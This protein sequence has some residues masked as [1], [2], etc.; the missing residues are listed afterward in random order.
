MAA[1]TPGGPGG[2]KVI[3]KRHPAQRCYRLAMVHPAGRIGRRTFIGLL[4]ALT[5]G[6]QA[7]LAQQKGK[8]K[9]GFLTQENPDTSFALTNLAGALRDLGYGDL[10]IEVR[11]GD[12]PADLLAKAAEL[13]LLRVDVVFAFQTPAA[14]AAKQAISDIPIVFLAADPV[15]SGLVDNI[16]HPG[17]NLTGVSAAVS[18]LGPKNLELIKELFP[19]FKRIVVLGNE[20]D[21]YHMVFRADVEAAGRLLDLDLNVLMLRSAPRVDAT[22]TDVLETWSPDALL[23]QPSIANAAIADLAQLYRLP[24]VSPNPSFVNVGGLIS[25]SA[26][27]SAVPRRLAAMIAE[28]LRGNKPA[29]IPV[30]LP[31]K[32]WLA[33]NLKTAKQLGLDIAQAVLARADQFIE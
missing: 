13:A 11:S 15:A 14:M 29:N 30:E 22:I 2:R 21:P 31:E 4:G 12:G 3:N 23:V 7:A 27:F 33:I 6:P 28:V 19:T 5:L 9:L 26:D 18:E 25:Y 17:G 8:R 24:S 32:F 20:D 10:Q 16:A 1:V